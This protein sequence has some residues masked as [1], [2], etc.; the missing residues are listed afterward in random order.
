MTYLVCPHCQQSSPEEEF[1]EVP[2]QEEDQIECD[3]C[4][5]TGVGSEATEFESDGEFLCPDCGHWSNT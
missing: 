5:W 3:A 2:D 4:G 1:Q